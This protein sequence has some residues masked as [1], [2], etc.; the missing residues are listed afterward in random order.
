MQTKGRRV[1]PAFCLLVHRL[2][3]TD[4]MP[5]RLFLLHDALF[6]LAAE[7]YESVGH[8]SRLSIVARSRFTGEELALSIRANRLLSPGQES[9]SY[10]RKPCGKAKAPLCL[11]RKSRKCRRG[12]QTKCF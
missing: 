8:E 11:W 6:H 4:R 10:P 5:I 7:A 12:V 2:G 1:R 9:S 3:R